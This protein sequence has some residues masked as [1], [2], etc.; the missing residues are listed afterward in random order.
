MKNILILA[1]FFFAACN[2]SPPN[3]DS[4]PEPEQADSIAKDN[5]EKPTEAP[6]SSNGIS[7]PVLGQFDLAKMTKANPHEYGGG[8]CYG[9]ATKYS[10]EQTILVTDSMSCGDY[11]S[12]YTHYLLDANNKILAIYIHEPKVHFSET[13]NQTT[14]VVWEQTIDFRTTPIST[15]ERS[16]SFANSGEV[17]PNTAPFNN[18]PLTETPADYAHWEKIYQE[19]WLAKMD[20]D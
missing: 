18:G 5:I 20:D 14:F 10:L 4:P 19:I 1:L 17:V 16:A 12:T 7:I 13:G 9:K 2:P 11:G 8:D 3:H 6:T 15:T